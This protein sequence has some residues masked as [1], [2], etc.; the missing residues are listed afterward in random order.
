MPIIKFNGPNDVTGTS[1][2]IGC[3]VSTRVSIDRV[4]SDIYADVYHAIVWDEETNSFLDIT[5]HS[6]FELDSRRARIELDA[7]PELA[8]KYVAHLK[9]LQ[10]ARDSARA[11]QLAVERQK[12]E[13]LEHD[14]PTL[15]KEM[16]VVRGSGPYAG[17]VGARGIVFWV[18][19]GRVGLRTSDRKVG[20][21]WADVVWTLERNVKNV[22]AYDG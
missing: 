14:R 6:A 7:S 10:Q 2:Y 11:M 21:T 8:A 19:D 9:E 17:L 18:R 22:V 3:V 5:T 4:M 13:K 12:R 15:N 20:K 1:T 16:V